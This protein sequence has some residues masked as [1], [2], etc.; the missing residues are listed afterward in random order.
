MDKV[1]DQKAGLHKLECIGVYMELKAVKPKE[2]PSVLSLCLL[3]GQVAC[4]V[5]AHTSQGDKLAGR[6]AS[7]ISTRILAW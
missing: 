3:W 5:I 6:Q 4:S 1:D 7:C 2:A